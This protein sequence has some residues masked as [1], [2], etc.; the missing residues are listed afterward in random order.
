MLIFI[1]NK[2]LFNYALL[3]SAQDV[4]ECDATK[5]KFCY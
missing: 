3:N 4:E 2:C 5:A 1:V